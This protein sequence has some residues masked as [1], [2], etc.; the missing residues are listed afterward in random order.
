[1]Q[2][3]KVTKNGKIIITAAVVTKSFVKKKWTNNCQ[4][5]PRTTP[6]TY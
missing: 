6:I 3:D 2:K 4:R 1:M 5:L